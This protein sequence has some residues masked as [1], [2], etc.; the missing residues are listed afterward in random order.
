[1]QR[2]SPLHLTV[3]PGPLAIIRLEPT[4]DVPTWTDQDR[5]FT[6]IT[7]TDEELSIVCPEHRVPAT[8]PRSGGWACL[9]VSGPLDLTEVGILA[10]L[11]RSLQ[12]GGI[13]VFV[14]ST[15]ETDYLL[16][17]GSALD[18]ALMALEGDGHRVAR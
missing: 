1:M 9:K 3:D 17:P 13:S 15:F 16:V 14:V 10:R 4:A 18:R 6:S 2:D 8:V 11:A 7:R 12:E 5:S